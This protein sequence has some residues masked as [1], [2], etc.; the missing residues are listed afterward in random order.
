MISATNRSIQMDM[1]RFARTTVAVVLV[2]VLA[3]CGNGFAGEYGQSVNGK[4]ETIMTF[5]G[6]GEVELDMM[7]NVMVGKYEVKD[8]KVYITGGNGGQTQAFRIDEK[9]CIDG[10]MLF[11]TMCRRQ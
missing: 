6:N 3:A 2:S 8:G 4:W 9:G 7:G 10:G 1:K 11:G 5:K